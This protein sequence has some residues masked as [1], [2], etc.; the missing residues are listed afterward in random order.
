MSNYP[1]TSLVFVSPDDARSKAQV[2]FN[3]LASLAA[4]EAFIFAFPA[5]YMACF[6]LLT[7]FRKPYEY[8][9]LGIPRGF[10]KTTFV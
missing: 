9:A 8:F 4:P 2:D 3:F 1:S 6:V 7:A 10:A 5:F